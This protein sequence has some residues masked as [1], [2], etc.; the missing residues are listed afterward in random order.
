MLQGFF[1]PVNRAEEERVTKV[2]QG[3]VEAGLFLREFGARA[4][5]KPEAC[6]QCQKCA[7]GCPVVFAMD[8]RPNQIMRLIQYGAKERLLA[9]KAIWLCASCYTCSTRCPNDIDIAR[10]M[11]ALRHLAHEAGAAAGEAQIPVFHQVFLEN[12]KTF[13]RIHEMTMIMKLKLKTK[14]FLKDAALGWRMFVRGK[15]KPLPGRFRG[16]EEIRAIFAGFEKG[17]KR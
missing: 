4:G 2:G 9:S 12:I 8:I 7:A 5:E 1:V 17:K 6:Y 11:D 13:G 3:E 15:I 10:V 16:G 14:E